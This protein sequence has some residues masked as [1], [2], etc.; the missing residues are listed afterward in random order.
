MQTSP[1]PLGFFG[2]ARKKQLTSGTV[3]EDFSR[4]QHQDD[5]I[6]N[7]GATA[8]ADILS[9][10]DLTGETDEYGLTVGAGANVDGQ[11]YYGDQILIGGAAC[12]N[13]IDA[14]GNL[15]RQG[16]V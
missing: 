12:L 11:G 15:N 13:N 2:Q 5:D 14:E 4:G 9:I 6:Q 10:E 7:V 1:S 3:F 8:T 16:Y